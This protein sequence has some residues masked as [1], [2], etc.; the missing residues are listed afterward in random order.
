MNQGIATIV[1]YTVRYMY[2][3]FTI[4]GQERTILISLID[5]DLLLSALLLIHMLLDL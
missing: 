3:D 1:I 4:A 5:L 2:Y